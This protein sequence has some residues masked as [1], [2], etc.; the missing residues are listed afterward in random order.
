MVEKKVDCEKC[1][2]ILGKSKIRIMCSGSCARWYHDECTGLGD[3][4]M[5]KLLNKEITW[6]CD[7]CKLISGCEFWET[8][9]SIPT[10]LPNEDDL[11]LSFYDAEGLEPPIEENGMY[12]LRL[13]NRYLKM[14]LRHKNF[15]IKQLVTQIND[16]KSQK[17]AKSDNET[18]KFQSV[19]AGAP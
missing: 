15:I 5:V 1:K 12:Q 2:K 11:N 9:V 6:K 19:T 3:A 7:A 18:H 14:V 17:N 13:N 4:E 16:L 10:N 8:K